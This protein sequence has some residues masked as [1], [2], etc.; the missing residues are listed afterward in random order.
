MILARLSHTRGAHVHAIFRLSVRNTFSTVRLFT[1][2]H[3]AHQGQQE[4][5]LR[6]TKSTVFRQLNHRRRW[7]LYQLYQQQA[8]GESP[9]HSDVR[10]HFSIRHIIPNPER[11]VL[12]GNGLEP[13]TKRSKQGQRSQNSF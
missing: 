5:T 2:V 1:R 13:N 3:F 9:W 6:E 7:D 11:K 8:P 12:C 10:K 4:R